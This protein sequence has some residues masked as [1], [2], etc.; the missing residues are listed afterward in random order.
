M[1]AAIRITMVGVR[2]N[3]TQLLRSVLEL[4]MAFPLT[5]PIGVSYFVPYNTPP[6][7]TAGV[8]ALGKLRSVLVH[9]WK[10]EARPAGFVE[11]LNSVLITSPKT[12]HTLLEFMRGNA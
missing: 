1:A 10:E 4:P 11:T 8:V 9:P 12:L 6:Y 2:M 7:S 5:E 3:I